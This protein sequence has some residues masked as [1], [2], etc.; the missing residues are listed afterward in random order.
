MV[1]NT[2]RLVAD[3]TAALEVD[4][5]TIAPLPTGEQEFDFAPSRWLRA[6]AA[7]GVLAALVLLALRFP[8][9]WGALAALG[10]SGL[11]VF[12]GGFDWDALALVAALVFPVLGFLWF[13]RRPWALPAATGVSLLGALLLAGVGSDRA[14]LLALEPFAGVGATLVVPP[15][16]F[17]AADL[18]RERR[19][20][21]WIR[22]LWGRELRLGDV[23]VAG[24]AVA[25]L[26]LVV[27]RRGNLPIIGASDLE[28]AIRS[29]LS[30]WFVRPRFK[31]LLGHPLAL[32]GLAAAVWRW[33]RWSVTLFLAGGVVAQASILN[34]FSHYHTPLLV[35]LQRTVIAF[36]LGAALG[37]VLLPMA[38][39]TV[40]V[41]RRWL[42]PRSG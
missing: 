7:L 37:I 17:V 39:L 16:L 28:L 35:S 22:E 31:E 24:V 20:A 12:A 14:A 41:V 18:L 36:G 4:G 23:V 27:I 42:T 34:S 33:P 5:F 40:T 29:L 6:A 25:A 11:G 15:A 19:P 30:E 1:E 21:A 13:P 9:A 2:T 10:V 38:R 26:G 32:L 8:G 3:L